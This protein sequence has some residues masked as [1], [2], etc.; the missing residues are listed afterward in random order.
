MQCPHCNSESVSFT[1]T[2]YVIEDYTAAIYEEWHCQECGRD[3]TTD[4]IEVSE[5]DVE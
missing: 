2:V 5:W 4:Y 3:F 1:T